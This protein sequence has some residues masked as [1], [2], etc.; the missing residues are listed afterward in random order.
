MKKI[1]YLLMYMAIVGMTSCGIK[2]RAQQKK[3]ETARQDSLKN[4]SIM[5]AEALNDSLSEIAW[6]DLKFGMTKQEVMVSKAFGGDKQ[7]VKETGND[8]YSMAYEKESN[9]QDIYKL[10][11]RPNFCAYFKEN[12]LYYI[13]IDSYYKYA[14]EIETLANDCG[15]FVVEFM[16]KYGEPDY[17]IDKVSIMNFSNHELK[18]ASFTIGNKKIWIGLLEKGYEYK[19]KISIYNS[20]YPKKKHNP[21]EEEIKAQKDKERKT[22]EIRSNSF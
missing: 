8:Y 1:M 12:E 16:K 17:L 6:G 2:E 5:K 10:N 7:K 20:V 13:T 15:V 3:D 11:N 9:I 22:D 18:I 14:S 21:T 19:Y 4:D